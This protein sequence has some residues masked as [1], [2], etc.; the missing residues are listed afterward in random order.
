MTWK[1]P[2]GTGTAAAR[3]RASSSGM[4]P[5]PSAPAAAR[6]RPRP[7]RLARPAEPREV[8]GKAPGGHAPEAGE[9]R[10]ERGVQGVDA[11][12][13]GARAGGGEP[14]VGR[15]AH[16]G[17]GAHMAAL[18]VGGDHRPLQRAARRG[19]RVA[20]RVDHGE[21]ADLVRAHAGSGPVDVADVAIL[22]WTVG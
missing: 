15:H 22:N 20:P 16:L 19:H 13:R 10:L 7:G 2:G 5:T 8:V 9:E 4:S 14:L 3:A 12:E 6:R 11:V 1:S 18:A 17:Q 21:D